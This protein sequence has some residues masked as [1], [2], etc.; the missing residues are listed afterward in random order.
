MNLEQLVKSLIN[1][2]EYTQH[3]ATRLQ[4][5]A[6]DGLRELNMDV[7]GYP[8]VAELEL[9]Q[10]TL[11]VNLPSDCISIMR[12]AVS[13][14][15]LLY[16]VLKNTNI[17]LN[18]NDGSCVND[19]TSDDTQNRLTSSMSWTTGE[20]YNQ[21]INTTQF[22]MGGDRSAISYYR[23]DFPNRQIQ[24]TNSFQ[25]TLIMEYLAVPSSVNGKYEI[26]PYI[27]KALKAYISWQDIV[28][29]NDVSQS[30]ILSRERLYKNEKRL[31]TI[32]FGSFTKDEMYQ[33]ERRA[34]KQTPN[35]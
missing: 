13:Y 2:A 19:R 20:Y 17:R 23:E 24:F 5:I 9:N 33:Y 28:F 7:S 10:N 34:F 15:D 16:P 3:K 4:S 30:L 6:I 8:T 32:R 21:Q 29:K 22:N 14:G 25:G 27:E 12:M 35:L 18:K 31:A 1:Q 26:H 11:I